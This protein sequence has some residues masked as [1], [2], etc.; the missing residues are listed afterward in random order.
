MYRDAPRRATA[1]LNAGQ[2]LRASKTGSALLVHPNRLHLQ[3]FAMRQAPGSHTAEMTRPDS[4]DPA[5]EGV[6][7]PRAI[8]HLRPVERR[9]SREQRRSPK[10]LLKQLPALA[11]LYRIPVPV[12]AVANDGT[13]LFTNTAFAQ[14]VGFDPDDVLSLRFDQILH[15]A[16]ASESPLSIVR[17]HADSVVELAHKDGSMLRALMTRSAL[18]GPD[19]PFALAVFQDLTQQLWE[20]DL[21]SP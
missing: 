18:A 8:D 17:A 1:A 21:T 15:R 4:V 7:A 14:L 9:R 10:A 16:P 3:D 12:L 19:D 13:I 20:T 6:N 2:H 5:F 11:V